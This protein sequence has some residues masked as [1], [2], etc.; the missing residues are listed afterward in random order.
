MI[1][2]AIARRR[3]VIGAARNL[4]PLHPLR[5]S[6]HRR[7]GAVTPLPLRTAAS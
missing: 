2:P 5:R 1:R 4:L 3:S 7:P 6:R